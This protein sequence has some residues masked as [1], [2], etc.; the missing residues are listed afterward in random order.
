MTRGTVPAAGTGRRSKTQVPAGWIPADGRPRTVS[1]SRSPLST[2]PPAQLPYATAA[3]IDR[4]ALHRTDRIPAGRLWPAVR[5]RLPAACRR[6][7]AHAES[8]A[9][10]WRMAVRTSAYPVGAI[11]AQPPMR[12]AVRAAA[13]RSR[14]IDVSVLAK[15]FV[16][17]FL[18]TCDIFLVSFL[19]L[20]NCNVTGLGLLGGG[21]YEEEPLRW[22]VPVWSPSPARCSP[23]AVT[24]SRRSPSRP[25]A[26]PGVRPHR[27][28]DPAHMG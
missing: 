17:H 26:T 16:R 19:G 8:S 27:R 2:C 7:T 5:S 9:F 23:S 22:G 11:G 12:K 15:G 13:S 3:F 4:T 24:R 21:Q 20:V 6:F 1:G 18:S 25:G 28:A 10:P 14:Q